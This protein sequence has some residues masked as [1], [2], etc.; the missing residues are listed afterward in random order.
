MNDLQHHRAALLARNQDPGPVEALVAQATTLTD[1]TLLAT[2]LTDLAR[3]ADCLGWPLDRD[4]AALL[5]QAQL[6]RFGNRPLR[7][8]ALEFALER[9]RYCASAATSGGEGLAR[10]EHFMELKAQLQALDA[11]CADITLQERFS[12]CLLGGAV[13]DAL[14]APVEFM[15]R[16]GILTRFGPSGIHAYAEAYGGI[17]R[18]TDDTQM[19]LFTVE[20]LLRGWVDGLLHGHAD[21]IRS[22]A[23]AYLRWLV[24]QGEQPCQDFAGL[25]SGWLMSHPALFST[26]APGNTCLSAL[27]TMPTPGMPAANDSKGCGGV[28]RVAPVGL[29]V[30]R[31]DAEQPQDLAFRLGME[32]CALTHAHPS[33]NLTGG[34]LAVLILELVRGLALTE[35]LDTA[36]SLLCKHPGHEETLAAIEYAEQLA[37]EGGGPVTSISMLGEGWVAEEALA[38]SLY[39]A[40]TA[41]DFTD[42]VTMAVNH[43]GDSDSTGAITGNL[44][45]AMLGRPAIKQAGWLDALELQEVITE[46]AEDLYRFPDWSPES[47]QQGTLLRKYPAR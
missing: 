41:H 30:A 8:Q 40:L 33:G 12:G 42:G 18:I 10:A 38:I 14:G 3:V 6:S 31:L 26:R 37:R 15:D 36:K 24:T 25:S 28:M 44:L 35:A 39:C 22:T 19:T 9:A 1:S 5:I 20:G 7:R 46:M 11:T 27:A 4:Y 16:A 45:G 2:H 32:L 34:V 23:M 21:Y 17:G 13:G 47:A 29:F 43:N